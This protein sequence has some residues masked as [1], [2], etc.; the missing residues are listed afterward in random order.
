[1]CTNVYIIGTVVVQI[2]VYNAN[3][4]PKTKTTPLSGRP[5]GILL[6]PS[7]VWVLNVQPPSSVGIEE[8]V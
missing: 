3:L 5:Y 4:R 7:A 1:M 6:R 8:A 2:L